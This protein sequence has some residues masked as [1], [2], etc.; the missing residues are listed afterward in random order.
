M[1][2]LL[3]S[4]KEVTGVTTLHVTHN[5]IDASRLGAY[6]LKLDDGRVTRVQA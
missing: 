2:G 6:I 5:L 1:Y 4:V 3:R